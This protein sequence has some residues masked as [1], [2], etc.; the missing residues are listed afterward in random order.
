MVPLPE[1]ENNDGRLERIA[2]RPTQREA[3]MVKRSIAVAL[4]AFGLV[5]GAWAQDPPVPF[6]GGPVPMADPL[7]C[8][9]A[10]SSSVPP[11]LPPLN[12]PNSL[13][14][15][16]PNAWCPDEPDCAAACYFYSGWMGLMR[17]K[18]KNT[19][20]AV[21]DTA[22]GG[23]DTGNV[24]PPTSPLAADFHDINPRMND[25]S[26]VTLGYHWGT[27]A[28]EASGY[29]LSQNDS[30]KVYEA[31]GLLSTFFNTNGV[32]QN[33]PNGFGGDNIMWLQ[34]DVIRTF[35]RTAIGNG[36][37]NY[38]WWLGPD[39][40]FS[41]LIGVRYLDLYERLGIYVGDDDLTVRDINGNPD[42]ALQATYTVTAHN[43]ILG[44]QL[45]F[46]WSKACCT[47]MAMTCNVKGAW[48]VNFLD[49]T[50]SLRRGDGFEGFTGGRSEEIFSHL[51]EAGF[52][53]DFRLMEN[54]RL[55]AGYQLLWAVQVAEAS[56]QVDFNLGN[57]N[58]AV[59]N[60][61]DIFYHGPVVEFQ[62]L[63]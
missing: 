58:G 52:F 5:P 34:A 9:P 21:L 31:P 28:I 10:M 17:Q 32:V 27:H 43:R 51:Y 49:V 35:L 57:P 50:T 53:L 24:P 19:P 60:N 15:D 14:A 11:G 42:P 4:V 3:H 55:R 8:Y 6:P 13:P 18:P 56:R 30:A 46:E 40:T 44:P 41:W 7:P 12:T 45:G 61:G 59:N 23:I 54:A 48:G 20:V 63:F 37:V 26:R 33:F 38:R 36:E 1:R 22:S 29:Y 2:P 62:L 25:G 39:S 47:W 16:T